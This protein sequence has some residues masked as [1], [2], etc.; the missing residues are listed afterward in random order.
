M[1]LGTKQKQSVMT[2]TH[3]SASTCTN[4]VECTMCN[5][6]CAMCNVQ[7]AKLKVELKHK[8]EYGW[9]LVYLVCMIYLETWLVDI[10]INTNVLQ[11]W[12][13]K[14]ELDELD[15][16]DEFGGKLRVIN[17]FQGISPSDRII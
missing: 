5:V 14:F 3:Q 9:S 6:Q 16:L 17:A 2:L 12:W 15:E 1:K 4:Q 8:I 10:N 7:C 13:V 11:S